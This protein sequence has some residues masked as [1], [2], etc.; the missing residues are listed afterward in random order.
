MKEQRPRLPR[1]RRTDII[2]Y[3][4]S[5]AQGNI[6]RILKCST[7]TVSSVLNG[8]RA[9]DT[10]LGRNIIRLAEQQAEMERIRHRRR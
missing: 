10:D 6:A 7:S 4:P 8:T 1:Q 9:Q 3:M 5:G 2:A